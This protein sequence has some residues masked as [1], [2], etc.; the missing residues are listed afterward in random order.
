MK[1]KVNG[2]N[3]IIYKD[4]WNSKPTRCL[5]ENKKEYHKFEK[6]GNHDI[7]ILYKSKYMCM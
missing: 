7:Y 2:K 6:N 1:E 4:L 3:E 5:K